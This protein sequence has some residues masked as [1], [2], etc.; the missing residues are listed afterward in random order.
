MGPGQF[1]TQCVTNPVNQVE[2]PHLLEVGTVETPSKFSSKALGKLDENALAVFGPLLPL[3][4]LL[5]DDP[6]NLPIGRHHRR[7][8]GPV[9][10]RTRVAQDHPDPLVG[11]LNAGQC[12][13]VLAHFVE[14]SQQPVLS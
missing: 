12:W 11:L 7:V 6:P 8:D 1:V 3:L 13:Q 2:R 9:G 14:C 10:L 4:L 5:D